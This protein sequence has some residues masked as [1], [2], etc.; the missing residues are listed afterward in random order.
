MEIIR[1]LFDQIIKL[2]DVKT[3]VTFVGLALW[4]YITIHNIDNEFFKNIF[5]MII[6]FY[7]GTQVGKKAS[8][9]SGTEE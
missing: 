4:V 5:T 6:A 3:I 8:D 9:D 2:I 1:K 7:F